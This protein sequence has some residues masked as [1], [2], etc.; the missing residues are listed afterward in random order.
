MKPYNHSVHTVEGKPTPILGIKR[1]KIQI[2]DWISY[3]YIL[4]TQNT[5]NKCIIG[6]D[7]LNRCPHTQSLI[8]QLRTS[9]DNSSF[10]DSN[11]QNKCQYQYHNNRNRNHTNQVYQS[12]QINQSNPNDQNI[13]N[14]KQSNQYCQTIYTEPL[15][16]SIINQ[17]SSFRMED[18]YNSMKAVV[19][20][21]NCKQSEVNETREDQIVSSD[22]V[23]IKQTSDVMEESVD[24]TK[25]VVEPASQNLS[26]ITE[27]DETSNN[28]NVCEDNKQDTMLDYNNKQ[29][30]I[31]G[32]NTN[33]EIIIDG[34]DEQAFDTQ[35]NDEIKSNQ[36]LQNQD[37][38]D[39]K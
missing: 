29:D 9:F 3:V 35:A 19:E 18:N 33:E 37:R 22:K 7:V 34:K 30:T 32:A 16:N 36:Q 21:M 11:K 38:T 15:E 20:P 23:D 14:K 8:Q 17:Q 27:L 13:N 28:S 10:N 25:A 4:V 1:C 31:D 12:T 2:G 6:M 39:I 5:I 26:E 24:L